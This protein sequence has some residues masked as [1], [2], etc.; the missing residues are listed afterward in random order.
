MSFDCITG[1]RFPTIILFV[2]AKPL[3]TSNVSPKATLDQ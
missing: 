1:N 2:L 3:Q